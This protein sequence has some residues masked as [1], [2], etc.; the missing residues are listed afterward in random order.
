MSQFK[1]FRTKLN[2]LLHNESN[3]DTVPD[4]LSS[5]GA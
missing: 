2:D 5:I 1:H 4:S 3:R